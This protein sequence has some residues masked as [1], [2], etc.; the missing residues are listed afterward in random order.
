MQSGF[1]LYAWALMPNHYH[2]VIRT[3]DYPLSA[4]MR[5]LNG[6]YA[7]YFRKRIVTRGYLFQDR[8]KS[9]VT[10][11]QRYIEELVRYVHLNPVCAGICNTLTDL[12][13]HLWCGHGALTGR[14]SFAFQHTADVLKRFGATTAQQRASYRQF[15]EQGLQTGSDIEQMI[16][17]SNNET[18]R[19]Q[20][21]SCWVIGN[22]DFI[23][24]TLARQEAHRLRIARHAVEGTGIE[25][26]CTIVLKRYDLDGVD[27]TRKGRNNRQSAARKICAYVANRKFDVP[28]TG[29]ADYFGIRSQSVSSLIAQG[30]VPAKEHH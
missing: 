18:E 4:F 30:E 16:R 27:L 29:I 8:Y 17:N 12:E 26:I 28:V 13:K 9:I 15:M 1:L 10:Q 19:S 23:R 22:P 20:S 7:Q 11:D 3:S 2:S 5:L 21:T 14:Q 25:Q 6:Q 24:D